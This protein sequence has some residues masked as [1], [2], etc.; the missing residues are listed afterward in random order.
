MSSPARKTTK[1]SQFANIDAGLKN[2]IANCNNS[3]VPINGL[4]REKALA[5]ATQNWPEFK[6]EQ[7][8]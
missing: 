6:S 7:R 3:G 8:L 1:K 2:C 5:V 4:A